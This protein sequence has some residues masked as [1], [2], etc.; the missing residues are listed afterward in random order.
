[1]FFWGVLDICFGLGLI[2][3]VGV[4]L[5]L[6]VWDLVLGMIFFGLGCIVFYSIWFMLGVIS[7]WFVKIYN[8]IEVLKGFFEVGCYF[9]VVYFVIYWIFFIFIIFIVFLIMVFVEVMLGRF[10]LIWLLVMVGLAIV[11]LIFFYYFW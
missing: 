1:M 3:Y 4:S 2:V 11:L 5:N 10:D 8:V 7:I 9:M 6:K